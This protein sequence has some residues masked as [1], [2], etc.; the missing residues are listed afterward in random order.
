M[1]GPLAFTGGKL[2]RVGGFVW[3][4]DR[5]PAHAD[6][7][8]QASELQASAS[9]LDLLLGPD[10]MI[11]LRHDVTRSAQ[12]VLEVKLPVA[13]IVG[14]TRVPITQDPGG[15]SVVQTTTA[16]FVRTCD[17]RFEEGQQQAS[18]QNSSSPRYC[19]NLDDRQS[20]VST[21]PK[22]PKEQGKSLAVLF[23]SP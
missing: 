10:N 1:L 3:R 7:R 14:I 23:T 2:S 12:Q 5:T 19:R 22:E 17:T 21:Q 20:I 11:T 8:P 18:S 4:L 16:C 15:I 6:T 13:R 9:L